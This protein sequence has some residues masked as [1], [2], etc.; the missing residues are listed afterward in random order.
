[1]VALAL[2]AFLL[3]LLFC[4]ARGAYRDERAYAYLLWL[5]G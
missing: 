3:R 2:V 1:L 5:D 4:V